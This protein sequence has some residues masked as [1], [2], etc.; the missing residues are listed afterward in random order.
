MGD[1]NNISQ[2]FGPKA[3]EAFYLV[4]LDLFAEWHPGDDPSPPTEQ[5]FIDLMDAKY[6]TLS[7]YTWM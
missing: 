4:L 2:H 3:F 7:N 1:R 5:E 6:D